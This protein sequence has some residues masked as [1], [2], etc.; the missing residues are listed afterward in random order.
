MSVKDAAGAAGGSP[1]ASVCDLSLCVV[2]PAPA[3]SLLLVLRLFIRLKIEAI[4]AGLSLDFACGLFNRGNNVASISD[5][6]PPSALL[7]SAKVFCSRALGVCGAADGNE[8]GATDMGCDRVNWPRLRI[9]RMHN[10]ESTLI[11]KS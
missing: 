7:N 2:L 9:V 6:L 4:L 8:A 10:K 5:V 11:N 3:L 1:E